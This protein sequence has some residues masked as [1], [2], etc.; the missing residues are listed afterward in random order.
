MNKEKMAETVSRTLTA[1]IAFPLIALILIFA[2]TLIIDI[3]VA[4]I[5]IISMYEYYNC[6]KISKKAKPIQYI[7]YIICVLIAFVHFIDTRTLYMIM[8]AIIPISL[9]IS[10]IHLIISNGKTNIK[11]VAI[12]ILGVCYVPLMTI[13]LSLIRNMELGNNLNGK[14]L[15]WFVLF[16]SWGSDVF[17]YFIGRHFGKHHF[18]N[19]S[20]N[21]TIEGSIA[22]IIGAVALG[23]LYT[24]LCNNVWGTEINYIIIG[25]TI[26][27]LSII[28]QIGDLAASSIKRYCE[29]KDF[30]DIIYGHGGM[31]D[32]VD[33]IIFLLPFAYILFSLL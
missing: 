31:L 16:A 18:T 30:G 5:A 4:I 27:I 19:I 10:F 14:M 26:A 33:S 17:A 15:I 13:Y 1:V 21:K 7:G 9:L 32:R 11:D 20:K 8:C 28:G 22:G 12:T 24:V 23:I 3:F 2:N 6:F 29:V 25:I